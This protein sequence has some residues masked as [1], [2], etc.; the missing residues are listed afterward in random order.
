[1]IFVN[2]YILYLIYKFLFLESPVEYLAT[3]IS[4]R[5]LAQLAPEQ[6][7]TFPICRRKCPNRYGRL[8]PPIVEDI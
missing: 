8:G 2:N 7:R 3:M 1:M 4:I 6:Q 5:Q